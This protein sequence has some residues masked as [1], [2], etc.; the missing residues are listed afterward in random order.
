M[1]SLNNIILVFR[2][3][4]NRRR[5]SRT[6]RCAACINWDNNYWSGSETLSI[7]GIRLITK[8]LSTY[9]VSSCI[10]TQS[11]SIQLYSPSELP[12]VVHIVV[13]LY[14]PYTPSFIREHPGDRAAIR[15][16]TLT[17]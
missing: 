10:I 16:S 8:T 2:I 5:H 6:R 12:P 11:R 14:T 7:K 13:S 1:V 15:Y 9:P 4:E 3:K 17:E